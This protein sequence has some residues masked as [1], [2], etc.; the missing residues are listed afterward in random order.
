MDTAANLN[1]PHDQTGLNFT[2]TGTNAYGEGA[3]DQYCSAVNGGAP[4]GGRIAFHG[5]FAEGA[6][7]EDIMATVSNGCSASVGNSGE[8]V[9]GDLTQGTTEAPITLTGVNLVAVDTEQ[10]CKAQV[11]VSTAD[12]GAGEVRLGTCGADG[13]QASSITIN[14]FGG[15]VITL[16]AAASQYSTQ[17]QSQNNMSSQRN[18]LSQPSGATGSSQTPSNDILGKHLTMPSMANLIR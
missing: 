5:T 14:K 15:V 7:G 17:S 2:G 18:S 16:A 1:F 6:A 9:A 3:L 13:Q 11:Q 12:T 4:I 8:V 10:T